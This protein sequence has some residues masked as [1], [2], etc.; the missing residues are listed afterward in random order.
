MVR[1]VT[2][3]LT[4]AG[5]GAVS[6]S[7]PPWYV[8]R[9]VKW[10]ARLAEPTDPNFAEKF[11]RAS[12]WT[13]QSFI[14]RV[15]VTFE[16][17]GS[18]L[19]G[20]RFPKAPGMREFHY[21]RRLRNAIAHGNGPTDLK[22]VNEETKLFRARKPAASTWSVG[23]DEVLEPLWARLLIYARSLE[24]GAAPIPSDPAVVVASVGN[25][26]TI[27]SF[28]GKLE[29]KDHNSGTRRSIGEIVSLK[30]FS[31]I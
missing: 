31:T 18:G 1:G 11:R 15:V 20:W 14:I 7:S 13:N 27:Q 3:L 12:D 5:P 25:T 10:S 26:L 8:E 17:F 6:I 16:S 19:K 24:Q 9:R 30:Y 4:S 21:T 28:Q 2:P 23:I 29:V 22:L